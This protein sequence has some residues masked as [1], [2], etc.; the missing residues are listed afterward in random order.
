L[1]LEELIS[2]QA[3]L[4]GSRIVSAANGVLLNA[5]MIEKDENSRIGTRA[6]DIRLLD[7]KLQKRNDQLSNDKQ[8]LKQT[9]KKIQ[10]Y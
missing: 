7:L 2:S 10:M 8:L 5:K 3:E 6:D 1:E 4:L 9:E